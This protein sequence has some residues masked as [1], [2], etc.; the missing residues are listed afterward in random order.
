MEA[1]ATTD[2]QSRHRP[3]AGARGLLRAA[4]GSFGLNVVNTAATVVTTVA[5]ARLMD[6]TG[7]GVYSWVVATVYL[8]SVPAVLGLDRLLVRDVAVYMSRGD[9]ARV[10]GLIRRAFQVVLMTSGAITALVLIWAVFLAPQGSTA[11]NALAVGVLGLP[12]LSLAWIA[13]SALM[14][15]HRVVLGQSAELFLRPLLLLALVLLAALLVTGLISAPLAAALFTTSALISASVALVLLYRRLGASVDSEQPLFE[16]RAWIGAALGLVLLSGAQFANSQV[17][18]VLLG[19]LD[20]ADSAALYAVAQRG[21]LLVAFPL[22][23][24]NAGIAPTAARLWERGESGELQHLATFGARIALLASL[25]IALA[26]IIAGEPLLRL[27]F[28]PSFT[29]AASA[30]AILSVGQ[31]VNAATGSV[32]TLLM[33]TG[34]QRRASVGVAVGLMINVGLGVLLIPQSGATGAAVAAA[35]GIIVANV[36]HVIVARST[37]GIDA[38]VLGLRPRRR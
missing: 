16:T 4:S 2:R 25:P 35:S 1:V 9:H 15:L 27:V 31:L 7:F 23:A 33:M 22:L 14:G 38:T 19:V 13:Q 20:G 28:G 5:L 18:T 30:L 34:Q 17:G 12:A 29:A 8:L 32:A 21:A 10:R 37:V 11:A 24:L 26:F 3:H 6:L 36:I